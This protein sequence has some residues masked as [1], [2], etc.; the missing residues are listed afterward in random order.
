MTYLGTVPRRSWNM[1]FTAELSVST[2]PAERY[3]DRMTIPSG[4]LDSAALG[5]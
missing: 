3:Q 2:V 1:L 4:R 5:V